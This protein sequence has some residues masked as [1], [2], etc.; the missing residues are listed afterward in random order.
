M[1]GRRQQKPATG[2]IQ[3]VSFGKPGRRL[4][5]ENNEIIRHARAILCGDAMF[6]ALIAPRISR[7]QLAIASSDG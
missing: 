6:Q 7:I 2:R 4:A 1:A 5:A 3:R